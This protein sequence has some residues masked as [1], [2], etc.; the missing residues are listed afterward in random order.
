MICGR[1]R[2]GPFISRPGP[3]QLPQARLRRFAAERC[4]RRP[5]NIHNARREA[6]RNRARAAN[7]RGTLTWCIYEVQVGPPS[8][9]SARSPLRSFPA[10]S[11][12]YQREHVHGFLER[13]LSGSSRTAYFG[14]QIYPEIVGVYFGVRGCAISLREGRGNCGGIHRW[15]CEH[16]TASVGRRPRRIRCAWVPLGVS[17]R[18]IGVFCPQPSRMQLL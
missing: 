10:P 15:E 8:A 1:G 6:P 7:P 12:Y 3:A 18:R 9:A 11:P 4:S 13:L 16:P 2:H 17:R 14:L 5:G